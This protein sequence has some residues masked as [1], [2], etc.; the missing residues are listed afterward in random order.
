[1]AAATPLHKLTLNSFSGCDLPR[2]YRVALDSDALV[3]GG[4]G[5]AQAKVETVMN[6]LSYGGLK[7]GTP[8]K[9][10]PNH[11][12]NLVQIRDELSVK[13]MLD[14]SSKEDEESAP[15]DKNDLGKAMR[16]GLVDDDGAPST[17]G[18]GGKKDC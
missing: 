11:K 8:G 14:E 16:C 15:Y 9:N 7:E 13:R 1:M 18:R 12:S 4:H 5:R 10:E 6:E 2:K 3:F 17:S